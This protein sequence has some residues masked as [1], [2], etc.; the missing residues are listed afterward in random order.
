[1]TKEYIAVQ[2][3]GASYV[4]ERSTPSEPYRSVAKVQNPALAQS[5]VH[6]LNGWEQLN[7]DG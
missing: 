6:K 2:I 3:D 5:M 7:A 4:C 1:M